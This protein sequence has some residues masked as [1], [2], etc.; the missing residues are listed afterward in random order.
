[1]SWQNI[2]KISDAERAMAEEFLP[3]DAFSSFKDDSVH[4]IAIE[5]QLGILEHD[6]PTKPTESLR[7]QVKALN[8]MIAGSDSKNA[9][10]LSLNNLE[11]SVKALQ[12]Y[13]EANK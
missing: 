8:I 10:R 12:E 7:R 9:P 2:L 1:M 6:L 13:L 5:Y 3:E 4:R 11:S